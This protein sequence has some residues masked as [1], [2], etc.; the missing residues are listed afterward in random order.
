MQFKQEI[1]LLSLFQE[2]RRQILIASVTHA[3]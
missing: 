3:F 1:K 2:I